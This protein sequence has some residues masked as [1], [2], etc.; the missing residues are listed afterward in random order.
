VAYAGPFRGYGQIVIIDHGKRWFTLITGM[1]SLTV[2]QGEDVARGAV[3]GALGNGNRNV[4]V[5]LRRSGIPV[6]LTP[7]LRRG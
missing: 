7:L 5:E 3:V 1:A 6:D 2:R 4:T